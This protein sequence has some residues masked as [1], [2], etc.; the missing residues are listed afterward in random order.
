M[1]VAQVA[2]GQISGIV[3]G[4]SMRV[5]DE[6][7]L[8]EGIYSPSVMKYTAVAAFLGLFAVCAII[9]IKEIL[10]DRVKDESTLEER[11]QLPVLGAIPDFDSAGKKGYGYYGYGESRSKTTKTKAEPARERKPAAASKTKGGEQ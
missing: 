4:S 6:P 10:D 2:A 11:M 9:V 8:P 7:Y 3:D 5:I 1:A